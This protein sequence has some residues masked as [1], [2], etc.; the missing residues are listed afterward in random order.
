MNTQ[1]VPSDETV[2]QVLDYLGDLMATK[3]PDASH[4]CLTFFVDVSGHIAVGTH[5]EDEQVATFK[6]PEHLLAILRG[7]GQ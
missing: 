4:L 6:D 2:T 7:E 1:Q 5:N 3:W